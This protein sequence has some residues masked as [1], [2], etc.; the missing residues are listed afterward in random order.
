MALLRGPRK[1]GA[2]DSLPH[3]QVQ[4]KATMKTPTRD[5]FLQTRKARHAAKHVPAGHTPMKTCPT[6]H[7]TGKVKDDSPDLKSRMLKRV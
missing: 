1:Q 3:S 5:Q 4:R 6:C 2:L 7:G